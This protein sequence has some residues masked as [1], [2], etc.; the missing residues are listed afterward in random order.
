M[1]IEVL[2]F[3]A[4]AIT[5]AGAYSIAEMKS[6]AEG[7]HLIINSRVEELRAASEE[8]LIDEAERKMG[9]PPSEA[10]H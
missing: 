2:K 7:F 3:A 5:G 6:F 4:H 8:E 1:L 10:R 9:E